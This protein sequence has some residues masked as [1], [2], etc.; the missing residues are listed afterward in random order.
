MIEAVD[1]GTAIAILSLNV[2][3][4]PKSA[5]CYDSLADAYMRSGDGEAAVM[6]YRKA[7]ETLDRYPRENERFNS[8]RENVL[9]HLEEL[10]E[11]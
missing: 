7:L 6:Y 3:F 5:N 8:L 4:Y 11:H 2:E 10:Q 1:Y 9:K